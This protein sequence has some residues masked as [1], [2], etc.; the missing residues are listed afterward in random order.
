MYLLLSI[1]ADNVLR[2]HKSLQGRVEE[3]RRLHA[4]CQ[5]IGST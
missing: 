1:A 3:V 4:S 5:G 2:L